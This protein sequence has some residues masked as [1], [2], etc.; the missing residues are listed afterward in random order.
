MTAQIHPDRLASTG[1]PRDSEVL[2]VTRGEEVGIV[3]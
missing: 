1:E 3:P 2:D